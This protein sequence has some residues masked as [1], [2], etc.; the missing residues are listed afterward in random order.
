LGV[1]QV[2]SREKCRRPG[3][4]T[5]QIEMKRLSSGQAA[6]LAGIDR[7]TFLMQ[8]SEQ[9]VAMIDL[10]PEELADDVRYAGSK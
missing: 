5:T 2:V 10:P 8:L 3:C 7:T 1:G 9:G 4:D 6:L